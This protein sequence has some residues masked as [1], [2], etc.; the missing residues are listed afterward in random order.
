MVKIHG[1]RSL[2]AISAERC[3]DTCK[4]ILTRRYVKFRKP[5]RSVV[6]QAVTV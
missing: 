6:L 5:A 1:T 4:G 2:A 3:S